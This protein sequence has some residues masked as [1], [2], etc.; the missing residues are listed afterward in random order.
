[1]LNKDNGFVRKELIVSKVS[2]KRIEL[3]LGIQRRVPES[4]NGT[5]VN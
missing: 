4:Q 3:C 2:L 1:M 5:F